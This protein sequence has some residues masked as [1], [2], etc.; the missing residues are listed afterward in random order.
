M[1]PAA[2]HRQQLRSLRDFLLV[3]N[4]MTELCFRHCVCN[5]N[6]RLLTGR[7]ESCLDSCAARLVRANHRLMGAYVGLVPALLQ[8]RAAEHGTAAQL[9]GLPA[10][11]DPA[12]GPAEPSPD[13]P[14]PST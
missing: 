8:R 10:S 5:L 4:R 6:Y 13:A 12:P 14:L 2:E 11:P 3:Y 1:D 9:P 7:E